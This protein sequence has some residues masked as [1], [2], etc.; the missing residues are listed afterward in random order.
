[1][2]KKIQPSGA[3]MLAKWRESLKLSQREACDILDLDPATYCNIEG[4][5]ISPGMKRAA[6]I[7][8]GTK[9]RV[10]IAAWAPRT[11]AA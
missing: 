2:A 10:P 9:G 6:R 8:A 4:G 1:M 3:A 5:K 11:D 7:E